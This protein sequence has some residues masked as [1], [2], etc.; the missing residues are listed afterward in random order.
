MYPILST[1]LFRSLGSVLFYSLGLIICASEKKIIE[2]SELAASRNDEVVQWGL[3]MSVKCLFMYTGA[4]MRSIN[5]A[6]HVTCTRRWYIAKP[7]GVLH[8]RI[9]DGGPFIVPSLGYCAAYNV[10]FHL[11]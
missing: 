10:F 9:A 3:C 8:L 1:H 5:T 4:Y 6:A 2:G 11:F 7:K